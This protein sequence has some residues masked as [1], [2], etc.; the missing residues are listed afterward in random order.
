MQTAQ[1]LTLIAQGEDTFHQFKE[2][3]LR[4]DSLAQELV[5][6]SNSKGGKL[7]I[8]VKDDGTIAGL[9]ADD[10]ERINQLISNAATNH[11]RPAISPTTQNVLL[12]EGRVI[13]LSIPEG[14]SKPYLD[15]NLHVWMKSG[16]DK[17]K[18]TAR[19]ELQ[20]MFQQA[21]LVHA[22]ELPVRGSSIADLDRELFEQF[23]FKEYAESFSQQVVEQERILENMN[24]LHQGE[25][26]IAGALLFAQQPNYKLPAFMVK[27]VAFPGTVI[28]DEQYIDSQDIKGN[29]LAQFRKTM[30]FLLANIHHVQN[31]QDFNSVGEPEV[32]VIVLQELLANALIHRDYFTSA[33]IRVLVFVDRIEII[34]PGHLPNNL[35][36]E[37]VLMGNSNIRNPIIAS[38]APKILPYRGLGSGIRRAVQ[39]Y[40][41][42][43]FVDDR[44]G[45][46]F[47]AIIKRNKPELG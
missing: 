5:A 33:P 39:A 37:K 16:A 6:F 23:F 18:V 8:G 15:K 10:V 1:L 7:F 41:A 35:T 11:V 34:S 47:I 24:L 12:P 46:Q 45:N 38:F 2:D 9:T 28:T 36:V 17:R 3:V 26:N 25:L 40:P 42:I 13:V 29:L 27:A 4:A 32:P 14:I 30:S 20:R 21:A 31:D 22:D 44:E 19:E 43:D